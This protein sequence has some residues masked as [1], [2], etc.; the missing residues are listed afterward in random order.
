MTPALRPTRLP[1][2]GLGRISCVSSSSPARPSTC[3]SSAASRARMS[4]CTVAHCMLCEGR[5][6]L[7]GANVFEVRSAPCGRRAKT[8][9]CRLGLPLRSVLAAVPESPLSPRPL[10]PLLL[11]CISSRRGTCVV[12]SGCKG[13]VV[14]ARQGGTSRGT[15]VRVFGDRLT[16][17]AR[18]E[19][20]VSALWPPV[21]VQ[22]QPLSSRLSPR[23]CE[24]C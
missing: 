4:N 5:R 24:A 16:L 17:M 12:A 9:R 3:S 10:P 18:R 21:G 22:H 2:A 8:S 13:S 14:A 6:S 19:L 20:A 1:R 15:E 7:R 11:S 23:H